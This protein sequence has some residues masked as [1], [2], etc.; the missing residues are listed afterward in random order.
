MT[1]EEEFS[2]RSQ[3]K[4][5]REG[6]ER[7]SLYRRR[8]GRVVPDTDH[9]RMWRSVKVDGIL[10]DTT[11]LCWSKDN[12]MAQAVR[13]VSHCFLVYDL[14]CLRLSIRT[15]RSESAVSLAHYHTK[16]ECEKKALEIVEGYGRCRNLMVPNGDHRAS[17]GRRWSNSPP[18]Q[19]CPFS[20]Q[21]RV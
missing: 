6:D 10:S 15:R 3:L 8:M 14:H 7:L 4:W 12:V 19:P 18:P 20:H 5:T 17:D 21:G 11:N 9:P 1:D 2:A 13:E 16:A